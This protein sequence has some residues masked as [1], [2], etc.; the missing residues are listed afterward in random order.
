[1]NTHHSIVQQKEFSIVSTQLSNS[2]FFI[3]FYFDYISY[4][5]MPTPNIWP[6]A[7]IWFNLHHTFQDIKY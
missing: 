4:P 5:L 3:I 6:H 7:P 2:Y 1:M